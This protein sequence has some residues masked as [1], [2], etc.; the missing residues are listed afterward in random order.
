M[1]ELIQLVVLFFVLFDPIA[2][3]AVFFVA[4]KGMSLKERKKTA[5]YAVF[6]AGLLSFGTLFFGEGLLALFNTNIGDFRIAGGIILII[7]G[8]HMALGYSVAAHKTERQQ[9][10]SYAV[11]AL[12]ATPLLTGPAVMTSAIVLKHDYGI[13]LTGL[14]IF[15][16]LA[17]T[18]LLFY[19]SERVYRLFWRIT[20]VI[21]TFLGLVIISW[22]VNFLRTALGF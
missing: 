7:L 9:N 18:A 4:T 21:S 6:V 13:F 22:G 3:L 17:A 10:S 15:I 8:I 20:P 11:A 19:N 16:V 12:I 2:S 1:F 14:A 5:L